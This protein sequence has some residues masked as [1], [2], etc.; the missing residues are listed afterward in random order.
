M[1]SD[2]RNY[3]SL[4][5]T[6]FTKLYERL[7]NAQFDKNDFLKSFKEESGRLF[8]WYSLESMQQQRKI[9]SWT[10][11]IRNELVSLFKDMFDEEGFKIENFSKQMKFR[12]KDGVEKSAPKKL[13]DFAVKANGGWIAYNISP[14]KP[15]SHLTKGD[16]CD[17]RGANISHIFNLR[18]EVPNGKYLEYFKENNKKQLAYSNGFK[19]DILIKDFY[20]A[21]FGE[22]AFESFLIYF[23]DLTNKLNSI[24]G[25]NTFSTPTDSAIEKFIRDKVKPSLFS[26]VDIKNMQF[27]NNDLKQMSEKYLNRYEVMLGKA[28]FAKSFLTQEWQYNLS[29]LTETMDKTSLVVG[30]YKSVE[31]LL[32]G[33]LSVSNPELIQKLMNENN[34]KIT[35]GNLIQLLKHNEELLVVSSSARQS[36]IDELY[37]WKN[38]YRN[39]NLHRDN[40]YE[41]IKVEDTRNKAKLLYFLILGSFNISNDNIEK[42]KLNGNHLDAPNIEEKFLFSYDRFESWID[43]K[44]EPTEMNEIKS[45]TNYIEFTLSNNNMKKKSLNTFGIT[46]EF[47]QKYNPIICKSIDNEALL[48]SS[49]FDT[50][51]SQLKVFVNHDYDPENKIFPYIDENDFNLFKSYIQQYISEGKNTALFDKVQ[52][53][54]VTYR[55]HYKD[56]DNINL[57]SIRKILKEGISTDE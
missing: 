31:Q 41:D 20:A 51:N 25:F 11:A 29:R 42:L 54:Y 7:D 53:I 44:L 49:I 32:F 48:E 45:K 5:Y 50:N 30:Y 15:I 40:L 22:E 10:N 21:Y 24:I 3:S 27:S 33:I 16:E 6:H 57:N 47:F 4:Y 46:F 39:G 52:Q 2:N 28:D 18:L 12:T 37:T 35:L 55:G 56:N 23:D 38:L 34:E 26:Q 43:E 14:E 13:F 36:I 19:S 8:S 9:E 17:Y 1:S